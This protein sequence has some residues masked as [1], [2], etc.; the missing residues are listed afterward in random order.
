MKKKIF[1]FNLNTRHSAA[2]SLLRATTQNTA[3]WTSTINSPCTGELYGLLIFNEYSK[4]MSTTEACKPLFNY[5]LQHRKFD[6]DEIEKLYQDISVKINIGMFTRIIESI[7]QNVKLVKET[8]PDIILLRFYSYFE[9]ALLYFLDQIKEVNAFKSL[10]GADLNFNN[11]YYIDILLEQ[12]LLNNFHDGYGER[13]INAI[14]DDSTTIP[15]KTSNYVYELDNIS[16][17]TSDVHWIVNTILCNGKCKFC[18]HN[19]TARQLVR[20]DV[21]FTSDEYVDFITDRLKLFQTHGVTKVF[22]PGSIT[23]YNTTH[24]K[25]FHEAYTRKNLK[26]KFVD[27][28]FKFEDLTEE[29]F[30]LIKDINVQSVKLGLESISERL[31]NI[32]GKVFTTEYVYNT[33]NLFRQYDIQFKYSFIYNFPFSDNN[34]LQT[35]L[36]FI[37]DYNIKHFSWSRFELFDGTAMELEPENYNLARFQNAYGYTYFKRNGID[38]NES[39]AITTNQE[40]REI[41]DSWEGCAEKEK[42]YHDYRIYPIRYPNTPRPA[43]LK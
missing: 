27:C 14:I 17:P 30:P 6:I 36:Q 18:V 10:G 35:D 38:F 9:F 20:T 29:T 43:H 37:K 15:E 31:R 16:M 12:K 7:D 26:I 3:D 32:A 41:Q 23:F 39:Q 4:Y 42:Y 21:K 1:Y 13:H 40:I 2:E 24:L 25:K 11:W 19:R 8:K 5:Y 34:D 33:T 28:Y 22:V